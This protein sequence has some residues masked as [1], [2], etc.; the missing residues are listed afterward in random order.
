MVKKVWQT[1]RRTDRQ[2]DRQTDGL[3][4]SYSCL[5]AAK[6]NQW[7]NALSKLSTQPYSLSKTSIYPNSHQTGSDWLY[8]GPTKP[9]FLFKKYTHKN[10]TWFHTIPPNTDEIKLPDHN[11]HASKCHL[12]TRSIF[13]WPQRSR[14]VSKCDKICQFQP[15]KSY[16]SNTNHG[17]GSLSQPTATFLKKIILLHLQIGYRQ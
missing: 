11:L 7:L 13:V 3:N 17:A 14:Y 5:V 4:Q 2:T 1:D 15:F 10:T 12:L 8:T 16:G 9:N 6:N